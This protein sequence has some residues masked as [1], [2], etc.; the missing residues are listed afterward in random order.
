MT[1]KLTRKDLKRNELAETV[2]KTVGYVQTHRR[3]VVE[4]IAIGAGVLLLVGGFFLYRSW[5]QREAGKHLSAGLEVLDTPLATDPAGATA[6]K[7]YPTAADREREAEKHLRAAADKPSTP[8]G[9]AATLILAARQSGKAAEAEKAVA[10]VATGARAEVGVSAEIDAARLLAAQGKSVEAIERLKKSV[11][12]AGPGTPKDALLFALG[13]IAQASGSAAE[14]KAAF[15]RIVTE[16]PTSP[17]R[18]D[19]QRLAGS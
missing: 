12:G 11:D 2:G 10:A 5:S 9:R 15:Q 8:A 16:F 19:A 7:T 1:E 17:Y 4:S 3:G 6:S 14:A 18:A 13:E